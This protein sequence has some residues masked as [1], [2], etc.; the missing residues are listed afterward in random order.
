MFLFFYTTVFETR[1]LEFGAT[2]TETEDSLCYFVT[3]VYHINAQYNTKRYRA[4]I[5]S[6]LPD[7]S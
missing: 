1:P 7:H 6:L 2:S 5:V 3:T 4:R